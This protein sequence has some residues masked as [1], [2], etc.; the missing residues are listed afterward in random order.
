M[1]QNIDESGS[2]ETD[3]ILSTIQ[4]LQWVFSVHIQENTTCLEMQ[5]Y[6]A[7]TKSPDESQ[8]PSVE[9]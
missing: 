9:L 8:N 1:Q 5:S 2:T 4:E 3:F 7:F 6:L